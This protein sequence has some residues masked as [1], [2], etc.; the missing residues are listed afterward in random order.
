MIPKI[1]LTDS[2]DFDRRCVEPVQIHSKGVDADWMKKFASYNVFHEKL[3]SLKPIPN[4]TVLHIIAVGDEERYQCN[5]NGDAF[6]RADNIRKHASFVNT[7]HVFKNHK[8]NNA[9]LAHGY[10][11]DSAHNDPMSRI[12]LLLALNND[13]CA[14][15]VEDVNN[16]KPL[17][18]SMGSSQESDICS[19]CENEAKVAADHCDCI[20]NHLRKVASNG[21]LIYMKNPNPEYFD[22]SIVHKPA[23]RIAYMLQ[24]VAFSH[25]TI[26]GHELAS[27]AG[28]TEATIKKLAAMRIIAS[29]VKRI[30]LV[31]RKSGKPS[32]LSKSTVNEL[33]KTARL[34]SVDKVIN[35]LYDHNYILSPRDFAD[36]IVK[37]AE[38]DEAADAIDSDD[39]DVEEDMDCDVDCF[40]APMNDIPPKL[41]EQAL[42]ELEEK[43]SM[44]IANVQKRAMF[45]VVSNKHSKTA[46]LTIDP[47]EAKAL[48]M[49]YKHYKIAFAAK[50][51]DNKSIL[52]TLATTF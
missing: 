39:S 34:Y 32:D 45:I 3:A 7:A 36:I 37:H 2:Y 29:M 42:S 51:Y 30:P 41:D 25:G 11:I 4:H 17:A 27:D 1:I 13:K 16:G 19:F 12:E 44:K 9:K 31:G 21:Q 23:D 28:Y 43:A 14:A 5:R 38:P 46:S 48:A 15:E 20:K 26:S 52:T 6:S 24:K 18:F 40:D 10:V 35:V 22:I 47:I 50:H 8:N 33:K 49:L